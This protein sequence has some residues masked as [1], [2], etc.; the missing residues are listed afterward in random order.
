MLWPLFVSTTLSSASLHH[1][2]TFLFII[3]FEPLFDWQL[4]CWIYFSFFPP[5]MNRWWPYQCAIIPT[6]FVH[7]WH[8]F[9]IDIQCKMCFIPTIRIIMNG[10]EGWQWVGWSS[11]PPFSIRI[12][13]SPL[14]T[15]FSF[16]VGFCCCCCC[17]ILSCLW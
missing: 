12:S 10:Y 9:Q 17:S 11:N 5:E 13:I 8:T 2:A 7:K 1:I 15:I 4:C 3:V 6:H 16:C 14:P